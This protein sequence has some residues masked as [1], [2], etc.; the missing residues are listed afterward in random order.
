VEGAV[1]E[2]RGRGDEITLNMERA[3][4]PLP[5][6][7]DV[8]GETLVESSDAVRVAASCR[9]ALTIL[10]GPSVGE[11]FRLQGG[12]E[13]IGRG[14]DASIRLLD[15][16]VS[17]HHARLGLLGDKMELQDLDSRNGTF[18]NGA[19]VKRQLLGH[20][21]KIQFGALT[22]LRFTEYRG[23]LDEQFQEEM[24]N[25][26]LRDPLTGV[27]NR[28]Y[29]GDRLSNEFRFA[30]RHRAA[31]SLMI[32]DIDHFKRINDLH[33]HLVGDRVLR[34]LAQ[35]VQATIR[36]EDILA[37]YG[38]EEFTIIC[39][40]IDETR[41]MALAERIRFAAATMEIA[42]APA[43]PITVSIGVAALPRPEVTEPDALLAAADR[44]LYQAKSA[45]RNRVR[46]AD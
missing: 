15:E 20:D 12:T 29:F 35:R 9:A 30:T 25:S 3:A 4:V 23:A 46:A 5:V 34:E 36:Q 2:K 27:Y 33:G 10:L 24:Y 28:R 6:T 26:A 41:A 38:G 19:R 21:D 14:P 31:L 13:I 42:G 8:T 11:L 32:L 1:L 45:G 17:R 16:S 43:L 40:N 18:V 39:R 37:R 44:A 7:D 22:V